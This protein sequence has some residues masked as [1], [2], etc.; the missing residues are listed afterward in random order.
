LT[1]T[2]SAKYSRRRLAWR[3]QTLELVGLLLRDEPQVYNSDQLP[4]MDQ[5]PGAAT[6]ALDRFE[7]IALNDLRRGEDLFIT[8]G[9]EGVRMLGAVRSTKQCVGCHGGDRG[10]LLGAFSYA[11]RSDGQ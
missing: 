6:R 10:D 3:V 11:L 4:R 8:Q 9:E 1:R 5:L 2:D 7:R